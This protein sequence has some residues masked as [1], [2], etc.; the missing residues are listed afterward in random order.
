MLLEDMEFREHF[1]FMFQQK[2]PS[3]LGEIIDKTYILTV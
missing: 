1:R 3:K 2:D